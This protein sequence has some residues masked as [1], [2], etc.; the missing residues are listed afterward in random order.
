MSTEKRRFTPFDRALARLQ[1]GLETSLGQSIAQRD[2][3]GQPEPD[4]EMDAPAR[5]H[6]AGP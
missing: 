4:V 5:R 1:H 6:A 2:N 3:P